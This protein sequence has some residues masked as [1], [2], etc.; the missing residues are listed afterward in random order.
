[1]TAAIDEQVVEQ[2]RNFWA[3]NPHWS[4]RT[5]AKEY[6]GLYGDDSIKQRKIIEIVSKAKEAAP[7]QPFP[8]A[9]W[10][11]WSNPQESPEETYFCCF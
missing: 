6:I 8:F 3:R 10:K 7:E 5:V 1:M 9:E 2:V 11:P 4:A